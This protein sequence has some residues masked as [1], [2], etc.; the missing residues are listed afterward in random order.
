MT[1]NALHPAPWPDHTQARKTRTYQKRPPETF[2]YGATPASNVYKYVPD[3]PFQP[4][5]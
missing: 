2:G 4:D 3:N 5:S 1:S